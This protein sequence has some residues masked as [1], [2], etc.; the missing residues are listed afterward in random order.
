M[1]LLAA[2]VLA[3]CVSACANSVQATPPVPKPALTRILITGDVPDH[4]LV[5][6][7]L[8]PEEQMAYPLIWQP[9]CVGTVGD[10][11]ARYLAS[12]GAN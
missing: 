2:L 6:V 8:T 9:L 7:N 4:V 12:R 3:L 11:R 1:R 5:C 10:L